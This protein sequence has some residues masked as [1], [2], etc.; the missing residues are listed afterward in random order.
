MEFQ[1]YFFWVSYF[2][3]SKLQPALGSC[4]LCG[5]PSRRSIEDPEHSEGLK[6]SYEGQGTKDA[7][8]GTR[9]NIF[10]SLA[11]YLRHREG[12]IPSEYKNPCTLSG[13]SQRST[14]QSRYQLWEWALDHLLKKTSF[15]CLPQ[16][17]MAKPKNMVDVVMYVLMQQTSPWHRS[18]C[19]VASQ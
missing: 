10:T 8:K 12:L 17:V 15:S 3:N 16:K 6:W 19:F 5:R 18:W 7:A 1:F 4:L 14:G 9:P 2:V 13:Q 11:R